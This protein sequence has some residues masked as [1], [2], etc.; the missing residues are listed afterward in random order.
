MHFLIELH[1]E[2]KEC[3]PAPETLTPELEWLSDYQKEIGETTGIINNNKFN[4][5]DKLVHHLFDHHTYV[6][7]FRSLKF[8][9]ELR[10]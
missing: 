7:H 1:D 5:S 3:F 4:G 10:G 2:F 6:I 8:F 9:I